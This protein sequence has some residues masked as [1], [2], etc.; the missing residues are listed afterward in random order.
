MISQYMI[1]NNIG[2]EV[3]LTKREIEI[4]KDLSHGLSRTEIAANQ[5]ISVNT[6]KMMINII[7]DKLRVTNLPNAICV[8]VER[9][10]V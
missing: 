7:Y 4:L 3:P 1:T 6:V 2:K 5:N 10:I 9:K 8:A